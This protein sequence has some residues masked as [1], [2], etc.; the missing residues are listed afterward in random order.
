MAQAF[1]LD[2]EDKACV[3]NSGGRIQVRTVQNLIDE[4]PEDAQEPIQNWLPGCHL[5]VDRILGTGGEKLWFLPDSS[6]LLEAALEDAGSMPPNW[7][8]LW[9]LEAQAERYKVLGLTL[10][11][12]EAGSL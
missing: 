3:V 8:L 12:Q 2:V 6:S 5:S 10:V 9:L 1:S 7:E 11:A 4:Q